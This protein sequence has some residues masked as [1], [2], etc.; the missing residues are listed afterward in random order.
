MVVSLIIGFVLSFIG[1]MP[2]AGP[3]AVLVLSKG[4]EH[5]HR[6][7]FFIAMGAAVAEA[8][9]A[10]LAFWGFSKVLAR[11]PIVM[12][13]SRLVGCALLIVLGIYLVVRKPKS[14]EHA[15]HHDRS[16]AVGAR[17]I[18]VGFSMTAVNPT[19][20]VTWTAAVSA[21]NASGLIEL[22]PGH[23]VPFAI[24]VCAGIILWFASMLSVLKKFRHKMRYDR[25][26]AVIRA[27]GVILVVSGLVFGVRALVQWR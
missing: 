25:M 18:L 13:A 16:N 10:F 24:G 3:I 27:M 9:Y 14:P 8:I 19:L 20:I 6:A 11:F 22:T 21:T 1:S 4:L 15:E 23:A 12:P 26:N 7:G 17:N 5:R 2:I